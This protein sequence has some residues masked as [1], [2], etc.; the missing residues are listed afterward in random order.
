[1]VSPKFLEQRAWVLVLDLYYFLRDVVA[2]QAG[3]GA[4]QVQQRTAWALAVHRAVIERAL[5][6]RWAW[7]PRARRRGGNMGRESERTS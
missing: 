2:A 5:C 6:G 4:R 7:G 3:S 1:V